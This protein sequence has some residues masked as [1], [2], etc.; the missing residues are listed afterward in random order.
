M[1]E[2]FSKCMEIKETA[3]TIEYCQK[4]ICSIRSHVLM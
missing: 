2:L 4:A 3:R 1:V